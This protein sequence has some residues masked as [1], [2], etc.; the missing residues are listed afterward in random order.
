MWHVGKRIKRV[1]KR[2][3]A[4]NT[5][6]VYIFINF[7]TK[8]LDIPKNIR[9]FVRFYIYMQNQAHSNENYLSTYQH[10]KNCITRI[11]YARRHT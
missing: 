2:Y 8:D 7:R 4:K 11:D 1:R 9:T 5:L 10:E 6:K 3:F